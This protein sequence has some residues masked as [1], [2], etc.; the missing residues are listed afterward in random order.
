MA[1]IGKIYQT[2]LRKK[3]RSGR[4]LSERE[5][6]SLYGAWLSG[7]LAR[8]AQLEVQATR[9]RALEAKISM[10]RKRMKQEKRAAKVGG[11]LQLGGMATQGYLGYKYFQEAKAR[12]L[13]DERMMRKILG[14]SKPVTETEKAAVAAPETPGAQISA[15]VPPPS[16]ISTGYTTGLKST[17]VAPGVERVLQGSEVQTYAEVPG[18]FPAAMSWPTPPV[19]TGAGVYGVNL[20]AEVGGG[21]VY[22]VPGVSGP[23]GAQQAATQALTTS[24]PT[25]PGAETAV[26]EAGTAGVE[27]G[28]AQVNPLAAN[29]PAA[30]PIA[31]GTAIYSARGKLS[32]ELPGGE[33]EWGAIGGATTGYGI[34]LALG[35]VNPFATLALVGVGALA[36]GKVICTELNRQGLLPNYIYFLDS[37][38]AKEKIDSKV[39][40]GYRWWGVKVVELMRKYEIVTKLVAPFGRAWA[41]HMASKIDKRIKGNLLGAILEFIGIPVCRVLYS[42]KKFLGR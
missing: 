24:P 1:N 32:D 19:E 25:V 2:M 38:Y 22:S 33:R 15:P 39:K 8:Q 37:L 35:V 26:L 23:V 14:E 41:Y 5:L 21:T 9:R 11:L 3:R 29:I 7:E 28:A 16:N 31:A 30:L 40:E 36:G 34:A 27:A 17:P 20:P 18:S 6:R 12:R 13:A 4:A 42:I 10:A